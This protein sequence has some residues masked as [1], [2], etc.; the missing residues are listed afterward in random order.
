MKLN[1]RAF[2]VAFAVWWGVGIFLFTWFIIAMDGSTSEPTFLGRLYIGYEIS[3]MGSI[4]GLAWGTFN[5]LITGAIFALLYNF[6]ATRIFPGKEQPAR[7]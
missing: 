7:D 2:A 4:I 3:P 5:A 1:V 6:F